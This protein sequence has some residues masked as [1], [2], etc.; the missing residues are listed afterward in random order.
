MLSLLMLL[1]SLESDVTSAACGL[2]DRMLAS[3]GELVTALLG[4]GAPDDLT[5]VL[6]THLRRT[7][8]EVELAA[9][10]GGQPGTVVLL[11][12]E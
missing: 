2:V 5:E 10:R 11:G 1:T 8:P 6:E 7:H 9:Y 12:V 3:G 4:G